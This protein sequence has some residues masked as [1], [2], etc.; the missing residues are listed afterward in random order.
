MPSAYLRR[1]RLGAELR[2][3]R[4]ERGWSVEA[5]AEKIF[6]SE[7]KITRLENAQ[8]R[9]DLGDVMNMLD[10]FEIERGQHDRL[11]KLAREAAQK[12]WWD[13]HGM[14]MGPRQKI[15]ADLESSAA[16]IR[17]YDQTAMPGVMQSPEFLAALIEL[18]QRQGPITYMPERMAEAREYRQREMLRV[19]GPTYE[20]V[21]DECVIHRLDVPPEAM[22]AQLRH[23]IS[24]VSAEERITVRVLTHDARVRGGFLPQSS[25]YLYT[26]TETGDPPMALVDTATTDLILTQRRDVTQYAQMYDRLR[27]AAL[28]PRGS[29]TF[30]GR[31]AKRLTEQAGSTP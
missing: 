20:T 18:D 5:V 26:F 6:I 28:S 1:R 12:G 27:K 31:V 13:R 10:L 11:A 30:L 24:L 7:S 4:E 3:I 17:S 22:A 9:P 19:D 23:M 25:F 8:I 2:R 29:V 21:L 14:A 15:A 16:T